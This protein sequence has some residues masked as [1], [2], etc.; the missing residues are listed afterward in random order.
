MYTYAS[1]ADYYICAMKVYEQEY[2]LLQ[3]RKIAQPMKYI[4]NALLAIVIAVVINYIIVR[5]YSSKKKASTKSLMNGLFE[6]RA[7]NNCN[8]VFT[9]QTKT[10][11]PRESSSG[12]S[13]GGGGGGGSSGGGGGSGGGHSF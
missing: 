3:G 8:V 11:S 2:T 6:Y 7:F 1:D 10:Y 9:H 5:V 12:G 13:S 4:S